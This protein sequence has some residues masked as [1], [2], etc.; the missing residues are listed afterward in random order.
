MV[1]PSFQIGQQVGN[2]FGKAFEQVNDQNTIDRIISDALETGDP[3]AFQDSMGKILSQV[4]P[5]NQGNAIKFLEMKT[6]SIAEKKTLQ[7]KQQAYGKLGLDPD[8]DPAINAQLLKGQQRQQEIDETY[9]PKNP[10]GNQNTQPSQGMNQKNQPNP[11]QNTPI[12]QP[13]LGE[14]TPINQPNQQQN[15][16]DLSNVSDADLRARTGSS[17]LMISK[18]AKEELDRRKL[19]VKEAGLDRRAKT[20]EVTE[21]FKESDAYRNKVYDQY[22]DAVRKEA[23]LDRMGQLEETNKLSDSGTINFLE[24]LGI[25]PEVLKNPYNEEHTKLAFDL[26][27]GGTL[28]ADYGSR[29]LASEFANS[30]RRIP[31]LSLTKEGRKQIIENNRFML[32]P[33]KLKKERLDYYLDKAERTGEPLPHDLRGKIL[34]DIK[35]QLDSAYDAFKQRNGRYKVKE[36][37]IPDDNALE[38]YYY[39]SDGDE[40]KAAKFMKEDGYDIQ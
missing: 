26:L 18:P 32:L 23:I 38:K 19:D 27:G 5:Q 35:P 3:E 22:E 2:N 36:G 31:T 24:A 28:Q 7:R 11:D 34:R 16:F 8:L 15:R 29:V 37:T 33:A 1:S 6:K 20:K 40:K 21:S 9:G 10:V 13:N 17:N 39:I 14:N 25:K 12:N 4:S 30:L